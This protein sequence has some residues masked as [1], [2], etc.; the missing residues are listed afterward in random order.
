VSLH[1]EPECTVSIDEH[2]LYHIRHNG[3]GDVETATTPEDAKLKAILLRV[4]A[5]YDRDIPFTTG[6]L[7]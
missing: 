7:A 1:E 3:S 4:S 2:G 6:D 5:I